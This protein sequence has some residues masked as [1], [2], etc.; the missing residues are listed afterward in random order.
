MTWVTRW[1]AWREALGAPSSRQRANVNRFLETRPCM[2]YWGDSWFSTMLYLN[3]A[4]QSV[5]RI[6]GMGILIGKP[7]ATAHGLFSTT[8]VKEKKKRLQNAPFDLICLSAGGNDALSERLAEVFKDFLKPLPVLKKLN[9][10]QAYER[11]RQS[12]V[13]PKIKAAY[14]RVLDA[15]GDV[16]AKR[17]HLRVVGH[18]YTKITRIGV[19]ADLTLDNIGLIAMLKE[20]VGPWLW[21]VMR[22]VVLSKS[23]AKRF[24]ELMLVDGLLESVLRPLTA[25]G[26]YGGFFSLADFSDL[27]AAKSDAFWNDEIHPTEAGFAAL[28][29]VLNDQIRTVVPGHK[30]GAIT[31]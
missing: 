28:A 29:K 24:A 22:H 25:N 7:G 19:P 26:E 10:D 6:N 3:L 5:R 23:E 31:E 27:P 15:I 17:T 8:Q 1:D 2:L 30:R 9:G 12:G 20:D 21:N 16:Q 4:R 18:A 14:V 11:L 13:F